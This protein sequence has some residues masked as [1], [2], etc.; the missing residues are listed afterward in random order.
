MAINPLT[1]FGAGLLRAYQQ[2]RQL[3]IAQQQRL[4]DWQRQ[5]LD[6][7]VSIFPNLPVGGKIAVLTGLVRFGVIPQ[8]SLE[9]ITKELVAR[10]AEARKE[11]AANIVNRIQGIIQDLPPDQ[12]AVVIGSVV[13]DIFG[14]KVNEDFVKSLANGFRLEGLPKVANALSQVAPKLR[15]WPVQMQ[16]AFMMRT[17]EAMGYNPDEK[18]LSALH[19]SIIQKDAEARAKEWMQYLGRSSS[20]A[21][22]LIAGTAINTIARSVQGTPVLPL[23]KI[24]SQERPE[25]IGILTK[26]YGQERIQQEAQRDWEKVVGELMKQGVPAEQAM[27]I[28]GMWQRGKF[29]VQYGF[30]PAEPERRELWSAQAWRARNTPIF[31]LPP[32]QMGRLFAAEQLLPQLEADIQRW[33]KLAT[34]QLQVQQYYNAPPHV[35]KTIEEDLLKDME[36]AG[37]DVLLKQQYSFLRDALLSPTVEKLQNLQENYRNT[38]ANLEKKRDAYNRIVATMKG[39]ERLFGGT[40]QQQQVTPPPPLPPQLPSTPRQPA[41]PKPAPQPTAPKPPTPPKP[42]EYKPGDAL[43][44]DTGNLLLPGVKKK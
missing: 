30:V 35:K 38:I 43:K 26:P 3:E 18:L 41:L 4:L 33:H 12:K 31:A 27:R 8:E 13:Q 16:V 10:E 21:Q 7:A 23:E 15:E 25:I 19:T 44:G 1:A 28:A 40:Q 2:Q 6:R 17:L 37:D 9:D 14:W 20:D 11:R 29:G 5:L 22:K 42:K 39:Y 24:L 34:R 36:E 32:G